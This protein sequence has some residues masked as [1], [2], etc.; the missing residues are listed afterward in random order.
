MFFFRSLPFIKKVFL[1]CGSALIRAIYR[2]CLSALPDVIVTISQCKCRTTECTQVLILFRDAFRDPNP[3]PNPAYKKRAK[4][5]AG[6]FGRYSF[7]VPLRV[8]AELAWVAARLVTHRGGMPA[9]RRSPIPEVCIEWDKLRNIGL[10]YRSADARTDCLS[11]S[12]L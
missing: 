7:P 11:V 2:L 8:E 12:R 5:H 10:R 6:H 1:F 3:N 4:D 9:Q